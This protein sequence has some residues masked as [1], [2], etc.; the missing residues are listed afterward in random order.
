MALMEIQT[1]DQ[2]LVQARHQRLPEHLQS[3]YKRGPHISDGQRYSHAPQQPTSDEQYHYSGEEFPFRK[4]TTNIGTKTATGRKTTGGT[5]TTEGN[6]S[7]SRH[8]SAISETEV[9]LRLRDGAKLVVTED[10][11]THRVPDYT[12]MY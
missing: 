8:S 10:D 1:G 11:R 9:R 2:T 7:A 4:K 12:Y 5:I 6:K 3:S